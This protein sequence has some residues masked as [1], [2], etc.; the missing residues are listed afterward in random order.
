M[1]KITPPMPAK[2]ALAALDHPAA[3]DLGPKEADIQEGLIPPAR[4]DSPA[5]ACPGP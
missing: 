1:E 3:T 5:K 2:H 4:Q